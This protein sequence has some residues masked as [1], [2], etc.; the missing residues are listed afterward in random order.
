M[1]PRMNGT[2][3]APGTGSGASPK[4]YASDIKLMKKLFLLLGVAMLLG[5]ARQASIAPDKLSCEYL[6]NPQVVDVLQP[7]LSW[8]N[9]AVGDD[10]NLEQSAYQVRV[11]STMDGLEAPDLWD[12]GKRDSSQSYRIPYGGKSLTSR[13]ECW[14]QVRVWDQDGKASRWSEPG[15]WRMGLLNE[16]DWKA[17]WIGVPWQGEE[18][19]PRTPWPDAVPEDFGPPAPLPGRNSP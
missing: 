7:R 4:E 9:K 16:S 5:C 10:R 14:W 2:K 1:P 19:L 6:Q 3:C 18:A 13:M 15:F 12:S 17:G 8:I 11:A